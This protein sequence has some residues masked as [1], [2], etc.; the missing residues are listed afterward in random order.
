MLKRF[1]DF[2]FYFVLI[3]SGLATAFSRSQQGLIIL[4]LI[5]MFV[6]LDDSYKISKRLLL[7]LAIW[8]TYFAINTLLIHS[9]H[10]YFM[11]TYIAII[12]IA[13]WLLN[14]YRDEIFVKY[15]DAIYVLSVI[16][17]AFV[18]VQLIIPNQLQAFM[19]SVDLS[20]HLFSASKNGYASLLV[21]TIGTDD[22]GSELIQH[23][24]FPRN[25]GF[26]WE[27]GPFS[28]YIVLAI[29]I[30]LIK[31]RT[32]LREKKRLVIFL[33]TLL[34]T[35][36]TTG[37]MALFAVFIWFAG[38]HFKKSIYRIT[39]VP[40]SLII[41][42]LLF[43][44]V[45]FLQEKVI[46][47]SKQDAASYLS[48]VNASGNSLGLGRFASI[49]LGWMDFLNHPIA[50]Y[51]GDPTLRIGYINDNT[52]LATIGGIGNIISRYGVIGSMLFLILIFLTGRR[53]SNYYKTSTTLIFPL[54]ILIIAFGFNIIETPLIATFWLLP[55]LTQN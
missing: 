51:G 6:F 52:N 47:E 9:F 1:K 11:G 38:V 16:S 26:C 10:P 46:G 30:N 12:M 44:N 24:I 4:W 5:G 48:F 32:Q 54:L 28:C 25:A 2:Y 17:L 49:G 23:S 19:N 41:V 7:S 42:I 21:Y 50:G 39:L 13:H 8:L 27:P 15:E 34:T 3:Y 43:I 55:A 22:I 33:L 37:F 36:S 20:G 45:P 53:I 35:Q 18:A 31:N 29:F 14:N 40:A